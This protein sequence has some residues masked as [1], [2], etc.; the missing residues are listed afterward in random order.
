MILSILYYLQLIIYTQT[1]PEVIAQPDKII[2]WS[3]QHKSRMGYFASP[4]R[5][6]TIAVKNKIGNKRFVDGSRMEQLDVNFAN[7]YLEAWE[8]YTTQKNAAMPG[9]PPLMPVILIAS[10]YCNT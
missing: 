4:Y 3:M 1:I 9:E 5:H 8:A 2:D 6:M 10:L 7:R